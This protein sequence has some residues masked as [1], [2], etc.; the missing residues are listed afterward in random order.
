MSKNFTTNVVIG[1]KL[2]PS[3]KTAF[4]SASKYAQKASQVMTKANSGLAKLG[5]TAG[6]TASKLNGLGRS[7]GASSGLSKLGSIASST[8]TRIMGLASSLRGVG[9]AIA[10]SAIVLGGGAMIKQA[11]SAEQYRNTLNVV[12]KDQQKAGEMYKWAV[13]FANKTPFETD[14]LVQATVKLQSYGVE[15]QKT[16]PMVGDMASAMGKGLDQAVEAIADAQTGELERLKEFGI[17]KQMIVEQGAKKLAGVEIVNNKGQITNQ[18]AFNAALFSLMQE[19][20]KGAMDIQSRSISGLWSTITGVAKSGLTEIA[21]IDIEGNIK[22]GSFA[23]RLRTGLGKAAE[24][25]TKF[26]ET[27]VFGKIGDVLGS[28]MGKAGDVF[29]NIGRIL[30]PMAEPIMSFLTTIG[31]SIEKTFNSLATSFAPIGAQL[32]DI[33]QGLAPTISQVFDTMSK[34]SFLPIILNVVQ[35][36]APIIGN[37]VQKLL[38]MLV[39][40]ITMIL[41]AVNQLMPVIMQALQ[42]IMP[43]LMQL[44]SAILP[45]LV[46]II[47]A[48]VAVITPLIPIIAQLVQQLLPIFVT[49]FTMIANILTF[50]APLIQ[51][52]ATVISAVLF[53]AIQMILP[54]IQ[55]LITVFTG[56]LSVISNIIAFVVNVFTGQWGSAWQNVVNIFGS[57]FGSLAAIAKAPIN[58]VIGLINSAISG[59]NSISVDVPDWVPGAG[60]KKLGFSIPKIPMLAKGG[61]T[62]GVSIAGEAGPEAV[63][64]L[65]P[66]NPRAISLLNTTAKMLGVDNGQ[67]GGPVVI[68]YSPQI[69]G[70]GAEVEKSLSSSFE[71][72]KRWAEEYFNNETRLSYGG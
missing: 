37:F 49:L 53:T 25:L 12:M 44:I 69:M 27:G 7:L 68:H 16:L 56:V 61:I 19:R 58:A 3:L 5:S 22:F 71:E 24:L 50:L 65:K 11:A 36:L 46:P 59:I 30:Q 14:E 70:G 72:F 34:A 23:D 48:L 51:I 40:V 1:G 15:A 63:I 21:G 20:Y 57:I 13:N 43:I 31:G 41:D 17:T 18:R 10:G 29:K 4:D 35:Q 28:S 62:Q 52:T 45:I 6:G 38:P 8:T 39:P 33:F 60:G 2:N 67:G 32:T 47:Q 42:Q 66:K 9:S 64:P 55:S 54:I 26:Q